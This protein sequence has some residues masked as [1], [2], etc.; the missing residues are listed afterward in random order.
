MF[1]DDFDVSVKLLGFSRQLRRVLA[2][3]DFDYSAAQVLTELISTAVESRSTIYGHVTAAS[4][5][6]N[7]A[8]SPSSGLGL[9]PI[10]ARLRNDRAVELG[11]SVI[12]CLEH[13]LQD[14]QC[15]GQKCRS[16]H[17][18]SHFPLTNFF[19]VALFHRFRMLALALFPITHQSS[20]GAEITTISN[21][22]REVCVLGIDLVMDSHPVQYLV[23]FTQS[24]TTTCPEQCF[25]NPVSLLVELQ[26]ICGAQGPVENVILITSLLHSVLSRL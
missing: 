26:A 18:L 12:S 15:D 19:P 21:Q 16:W 22:I 25:S 13:G 20:H 10:W 23:G 6:L 4:T 5:A 24:G 11:S 3:D 14:P 7:A 1:K 8:I 17:N 2:S 9:V